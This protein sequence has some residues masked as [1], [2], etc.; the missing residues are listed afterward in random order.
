[1]L[2]IAPQNT[3][4]NVVNNYDETLTSLLE[5]AKTQNSTEQEKVEIINNLL[6]MV[7]ETKPKSDQKTREFVW[8]E[9]P[10][11]KAIRKDHFHWLSFFIFF[12]GQMGEELFTLMDKMEDE[13]EKFETKKWILRFF[14]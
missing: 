12:G 13:S 9:E 5:K 2:L 6:K 8:E 4:V 7:A 10:M 11:K 14:K 3:D 1:M